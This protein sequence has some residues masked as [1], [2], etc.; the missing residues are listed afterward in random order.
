ME[1]T[2]WRR[3]AIVGALLW[4]ALIF[5]VSSRSTLPNPGGLSPDLLA[6]GGHFFVYAVLAAL[7]R[8]GL[9][10]EQPDRRLDILAIAFATLYGLTDEFHQSFVP[11]RD[12]SSFDILIDLIGATAGVTF[13]Y[14]LRALMV[15]SR[16]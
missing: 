2:S 11:G 16:R 8:L 9:G 10:F 12:P 1:R 5:A 15:G 4:M 3:P 7:I 14:L 13:T 6:I